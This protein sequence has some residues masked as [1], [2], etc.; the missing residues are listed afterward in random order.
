MITFSE[1]VGEKVFVWDTPKRD[2]DVRFTRKRYLKVIKP[3][4]W[5]EQPLP[6]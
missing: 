5:Y 6:R 2:K 1:F 3:R 4:L